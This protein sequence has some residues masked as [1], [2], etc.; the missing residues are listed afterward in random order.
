M[1]ALIFGITG[2]DGYYL[3]NICSQHNV[4]IIGVSRNNK[5]WL[6]GDISSFEFVEKT[7]KELKPDYIFHLAANSTTQHSAVFE[8]YNTITTGTLNILESVL[9]HSPQSKV[10]LSGSALQFR[11]NG[12]PINE[13]MPLEARDAYSVARIQSLYWARYYRSIGIKTYMGFF[14]NHD[15]PL[16]TAR[17][18][19]QKI[20]MTVKRIANGSKEKLFIGDLHAKKEFSFAGDI[21]EAVWILVNQDNIYEAVIGSGEAHEICDFVKG[22]FDKVHLDYR[23]FIEKDT[24]FISTYKVLVCDPTIIMKL[25]WHPV[26][27]FEQIIDMMMKA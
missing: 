17:H 7:I 12:S 6:V 20:A 25:G 23:R 18:L 13:N 5:N 11:N 4:E 14:F 8:N 24:R 9:Q 27:S 26:I 16:R 15:S 21:M 3:S 1:K 19:N 10:F 2:Q 22:C